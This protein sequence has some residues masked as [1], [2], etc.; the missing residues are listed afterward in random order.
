MDDEEQMLST[1]DNPYD[2][3]TQWDEWLAYDYA[4]GHHTCEYLARISANSTDLS[5]SS[6][7]YYDNLAMKEIINNDP[8][9]L[10]MIV[11]R[12]TFKNKRKV[13]S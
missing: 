5:E 12:N 13:V 10:Y 11:N 3:F 2:P 8:I 7:Q 9:G 4:K 1:V 6:Q